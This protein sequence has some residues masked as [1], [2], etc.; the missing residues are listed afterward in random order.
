MTKLGLDVLDLFLIHWPLPLLDR[1]VETWRA[2][3]YLHVNG[4]V[5]SIGVSN[6]TVSQLERLIRETDVVPAV[7]QVELHPEFAQ[8]DLRDFH[9]SQG[10]LT[11][12]WGPLGQGKGLL[13]NP[14][15]IE[16]AASKNRSPAQV[17]LRW[18]L[19]LG[20]V[21]IPKSVTPR[22]IRENV[23]IFDFEL[24]TDDMQAIAQLDT[25]R[26]L[27]PDPETFDMR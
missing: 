14:R 3:E 19:Q 20:N 18:H 12:A 22:R 6:F 10:I 16:V 15:I 5:R 11:Q 21:V 8:Q 9:A 26:R 24:D 7:N 25:G 1:Y 17:V 4:R 27:G 13:K 2:L 23:E